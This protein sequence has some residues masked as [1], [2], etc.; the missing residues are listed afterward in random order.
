MPF[1][2]WKYRLILLPLCLLMIQCERAT[3]DELS[4]NI[5]PYGLGSVNLEDYLRKVDSLPLKGQKLIDDQ[6]FEGDYT[7]LTK[8][9]VWKHSG[10]VVFEGDFF[11]VKKVTD[12]KLLSSKVNRIKIESPL[13]STAQGI[14]IGTSFE[15]L[16]YVFP[17]SSMLITPFPDYNMIEVFVPGLSPF[18]YLFPWNNEHQSDIAPMDTIASIVIM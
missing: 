7:W 12:Q 10:K 8:T 9:I 2:G 18:H 17:D 3:L 15:E 13:F 4:Y 16:S 5:T 6:V 14:N 1:T 11:E